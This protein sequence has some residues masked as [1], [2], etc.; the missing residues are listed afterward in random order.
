MKSK[1]CYYCGEPFNKNNQP[2]FD[3]LVPKSRGGPD[4]K[5]NKVQACFFCN[6]DKG[7]KTIYKGVDMYKLTGYKKPPFVKKGEKALLTLKTMQSFAKFFETLPEGEQEFI[8]NSLI[9]AFRTKI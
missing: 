8:K 4:V 1:T 9:E 3:H 2:T 5:E 6:Q 7:Q